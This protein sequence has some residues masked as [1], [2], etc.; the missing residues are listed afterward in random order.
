MTAQSEAISHKRKKRKQQQQHPKTSIEAASKS[1]TQ[2]PAS[3]A[4]SAEGSLGF[5]LD[6]GGHPY[7]VRPLGNMYMDGSSTNARDISLGALATL[8]D[9]LLIDILSTLSAKDLCAFGLTSRACYLFT[10]HEELWRNLY[11]GS[12]FA[13]GLFKF[14]NNWKTT[15]RLHACKEKESDQSLLHKRRV[16]MRGF[17]SDCLFRP[18]LCA[19]MAMKPEWLRCNNIARWSC[20]ELS[21]ADFIAQFEVPNRPVLITGLVEK[22]PAFTR[23]TREYLLE[24]ARDGRFAV[25]PLS[26]TLADYY[27]YADEVCEE[28]PLYLFDK[29]FA[30]KVPQ[31]GKDYPVPEYF[32]ED[33]FSVLGSKRP[34]YRWLIIGPKGS[35]SSFHVDPNSTSA[36]N[37]VISGRKKWIMYPPGTVPPGVHPS[38]D[39]ADVATPVSITEWFMNF[40]DQ[41]KKMDVKPVECVCEAGEVVF[42]PRG[43]W[44]TVVNLEASVAVTQNYVSRRNL[45]DVLDFLASPNARDLVSG[46]DDAEGL[47]ARFRDAFE[48]EFPGEIER[49]RRERREQ[50]EAKQKMKTFWDA[51]ADTPFKLFG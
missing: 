13:E 51:A 32:R 21:V 28:R 7:G 33:L 6:G 31:F 24:H 44:H 50:T 23:W 18:W 11:L 3:T 37:A 4:K 10:Q 48:A 12:Q 26:L 45:L 2:N 47:F 9:E 41:T 38:K 14:H 36:W 42:V 22:W 29:R 27:A 49:L 35:G 15:Y 30:D 1:K 25:G 43:W 34:D 19:S 16:S 39:G 40:Y 46:T 17:Y 5:D 20:N 8:T